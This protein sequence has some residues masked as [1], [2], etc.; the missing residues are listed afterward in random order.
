MK[1]SNY[2]DYVKFKTY[3]FKGKFAVDTRV[4]FLM[5]KMLEEEL[6]TEQILKIEKILMKK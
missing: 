1:S 4:I 3:G 2:Y 5:T 6:T